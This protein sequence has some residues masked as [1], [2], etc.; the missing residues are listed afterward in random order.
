MNIETTRLTPIAVA[1][2]ALILSSAAA[3]AMA[4]QAD[5][6]R[7]NSVIVTGTRTAKAVDKIPGAV[8][9]ISAAEVSNSLAISEDATAVLARVVPGYSEPTQA[10]SNAGETL[11][12][13]IALRLFDGIPQTSP[14]RE[15]NRSGSF[16]DL[17]VVGRIEVINGPSASE[18][19]GAAGGIIN[20]ISKSP[21][22]MGN[23]TIITSK[24]SSQFHDDSAGYKLGVEFMHKDEDY[25]LLFST[26]E[27]D[28]GI[29]LRRAKAA[30]SV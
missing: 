20:Y 3:S 18:G 7:E 29:G 24:V 30:G 2:G 13:R 6:A 12:G 17:G 23:Q 10:M 14:L 19:V 26:S 15:T 8:S 1:I 28:R 21:K 9:V 25:D 16:T 22:V 27:V 11:R 4:Q 5:V